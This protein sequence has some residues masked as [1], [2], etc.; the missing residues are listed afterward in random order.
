MA[1]VEV[2][3]KDTGLKVYVNTAHIEKII[4]QSGST[5]AF[6]MLQMARETMEVLGSA[7]ENAEKMDLATKEFN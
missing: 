4:S 6:S 5:G 2:T 1:F 7:K 3:K